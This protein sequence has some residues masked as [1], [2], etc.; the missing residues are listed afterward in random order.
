MGV[1]YLICFFLVV[2]LR[3]TQTMRVEQERQIAKQRKRRDFFFA[4]HLAD[5]KAFVKKVGMSA[6][7]DNSMSDDQLSAHPRAATIRD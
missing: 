2:L 7:S 1:Y 4:S 6:L 5:L 3:L